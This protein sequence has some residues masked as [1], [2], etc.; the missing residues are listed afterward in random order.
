MARRARLA[1]LAYSYAHLGMVGGI[2]AIAAG[3]HDAIAHLGGVLDASHAW[4]LAGGVALYLLSDKWFRFLVSIGP[5]HYRGVAALVALATA[6]IGWRWS[7]AGQI[8]AL[9]MIFVVMLA[10]ERA[11]SSR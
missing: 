4:V 2:V 8:A 7:S 5:S 3:L 6:P 10:S 1:V 9:T 11:G